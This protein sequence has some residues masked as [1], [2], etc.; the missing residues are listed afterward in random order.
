MWYIYSSIYKLNDYKLSFGYLYMKVESNFV[1]KMYMYLYNWYND[2]WKSGNAQ[3][4]GHTVPEY[5]PREA[6][7]FYSRW[8]HGNSI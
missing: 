8:L 6:L 7:D 3:G 2:T 1:R 5:K 4:A